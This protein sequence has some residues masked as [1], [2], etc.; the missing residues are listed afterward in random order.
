MSESAYN[1]RPSHQVWIQEVL[2]EEVTLKLR[3]ENEQKVGGGGNW[4][5]GGGMA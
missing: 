3:T 4:F 5:P 1:R 2:L